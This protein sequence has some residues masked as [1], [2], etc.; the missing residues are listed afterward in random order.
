MR[1]AGP[2]HAPSCRCDTQVR[3]ANMIMNRCAAL[4]HPSCGIGTVSMF[5]LEVHDLIQK[6]LSKG[7]KKNILSIYK[8][9]NQRQTNNILKNTKR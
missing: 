1:S 5:A 2:K 8:Y 6:L 3:K 4:A 7:H 9:T